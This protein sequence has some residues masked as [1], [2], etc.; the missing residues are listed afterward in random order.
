MEDSQE[1]NERQGTTFL[2]SL[3][4]IIEGKT[5]IGPKI[6]NL[7]PPDLVKVVYDAAINFAFDDN[8]GDEQGKKTYEWLGRD[9]GIDLEFISKAHFHR[10]SGRRNGCIIYVYP[11][12]GYTDDEKATIRK[13]EIPL[14]EIANNTIRNQHF[15]ATLNRIPYENL[16]QFVDTYDPDQ[17]KDKVKE[18][19]SAL[20]EISKQIEN[21]DE[22]NQKV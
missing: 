4:A 21:K 13:K 3:I 8:D 11:D 19:E 16:V 22:T 14:L 9:A 20:V 1:L 7:L 5:P 17:R 15:D 12:N 6:L 10:K 2:K 18:L